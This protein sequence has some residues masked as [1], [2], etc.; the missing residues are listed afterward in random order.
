MSSY[1]PIRVDVEFMDGER[2]GYDCGGMIKPREA[3]LENEGVL[4][5][6]EKNGEGAPQL[7]VA[8]LPLA[9]IRVYTAVRRA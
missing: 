5:L 3:I 2:R 6:W 8:S 9:N 7:H 4:T 1:N